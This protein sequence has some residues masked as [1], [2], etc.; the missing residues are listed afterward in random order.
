MR[1]ESE[2]AFWRA[3]LAAIDNTPEGCTMGGQGGRREK[4]APEVHLENPED[5][6]PSRV[7]TGRDYS[8]LQEVQEVAETLA[9]IKEGAQQTL[10]ET[11]E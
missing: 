9:G 5:P 1:I 8:R 7:V 3:A 4:R 11:E 6:T 2:E 10:P